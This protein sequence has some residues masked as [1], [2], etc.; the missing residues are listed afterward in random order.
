MLV[1][2][3]GECCFVGYAEAKPHSIF[4][5]SSCLPLCSFLCCLRV[6]LR[7]LCWYWFCF[8]TFSPFSLSS[9]LLC[10]ILSIRFLTLLLC[11]SFSQYRCG[12]G[13]SDCGW[14]VSSVLRYHVLLGHL[15]PCTWWVCVGGVPWA[16]ERGVLHVSWEKAELPVKVW[17]LSVSGEAK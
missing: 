5:C 16:W 11:S 10:F 14:R 9:P 6:L 17:W 2:T 3:A 12:L 8:I 1:S 13:I 4:L 15:P 7:V